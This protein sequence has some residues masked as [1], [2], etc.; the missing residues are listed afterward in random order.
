MGQGGWLRGARLAPPPRPKPGSRGL[1]AASC[2]PLQD[3]NRR[4]AAGCDRQQRRQGGRVHQ[5]AG[6]LR[7]HRRRHHL[8]REES[9]QGQG[10]AGAPEGG[11]RH[12]AVGLLGTPWPACNARGTLMH[13]D[14]ARQQPWA[15]PCA[16]LVPS[17]PPPPHAP[18]CP[19][20]FHRRADPSPVLLAMAAGPGGQ[21]GDC[22]DEEGGAAEGRQVRAWLGCG[23][24]SRLRA[25]QRSAADAPQA[26]PS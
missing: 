7:L 20:A 11:A 16:R 6:P 3:D 23:S 25:S 8:L 17:P 14:A 1:A 10:H 4:L 18:P 13:G 9:D 15:G 21:G 5:D 19:G 12:A 2:G 22:G 26:G 24:L